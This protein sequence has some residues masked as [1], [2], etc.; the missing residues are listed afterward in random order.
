MI[1]R[2]PKREAAAIINSLSSGVVPRIG[3]RHI[4]VGRLKEV[5]AFVH[6]LDTINNDGGAIR[7]VCGRYGSGKSF[8]LQMIRNNALDRNFVVMDADLSPERRL[9]G[10]QGKG[11]ATYKE[12]IQNLSTKTRPEG[13]ALESIL[14]KWIVS[15][16]SKI[17]RK[18]NLPPNDPKLINAV[19]LK[20]QEDLGELTEMAYG[21]SFSH[22]LNAYWIGMKTGD[23]QLKQSALRWIRGE[24][25]TKRDA[26]K[27]L[28]VDSIIN[29]KNWY[30]FLKLFAK[31]VKLAEFSGLVIFLDEGVNLYKINHKVARENNYEKLLTI[32]NDLS[33]G[34]AQNIGIFFSETPEAIYDER[35]GLFSYEALRSRLALNE[36]KTD[37]YIDNIGPVIALQVLT[38]EELFILLE[39]IIRVYERHYNYNPNL[40]REQLTAFLQTIMNRLG[41]DDVITPREIIKTF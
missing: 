36:F 26:R 40:S 9:Y 1:N 31:F 8:L 10:S 41:A 21:Y 27:S 25:S 15:I 28:D 6:D 17:A 3:T 24:F 30:E 35:R 18:M 19:S 2:I 37:E 20:I 29:D 16:Q 14:Q 39:N 5:N 11:L 38:T 34:K 12:L 23:D 7:F 22:V 4:A 32:F 13:R 33:Q